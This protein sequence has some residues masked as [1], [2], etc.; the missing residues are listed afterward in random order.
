MIYRGLV[1]T[2][3]LDVAALELCAPLFA[4]DFVLTN[5][6]TGMKEMPKLSFVLS[7][8]STSETEGGAEGQDNFEIMKELPSGNARLTATRLLR[9]K[10]VSSYVSEK[11]GF[12][13]PKSRNNSIAGSRR[14]SA[15]ANALGNAHGS[16]LSMTALAA[17]AATEK[18]NSSLSSSP[19]GIAPSNASTS[20]STSNPISLRSHY[21]SLMAQGVIQPHECIEILVSGKVLPSDATLA[22]CQRFWWKTPED[23]KLEYRWKRRLDVEMGEEEG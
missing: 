5:N 2:L 21:V 20:S 12:S 1:R 4:L 3:S 14:S 11:L 22:Q 8:C 15:D 17:K 6:I 19:N 7:P 16:G 9:M 18:V 13:V 10:K 23:I